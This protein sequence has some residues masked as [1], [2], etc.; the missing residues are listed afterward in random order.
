MST[1]LVRR[2]LDGFIEV[3]AE[4]SID[5]VVVVDDRNPNNRVEF[6]RERYSSTEIEQTIGAAQ[7][8]DLSMEIIFKL[9]AMSNGR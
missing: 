7:S 8:E 5:S 1:V 2:H 9:Q 6:I 4:G 3:M